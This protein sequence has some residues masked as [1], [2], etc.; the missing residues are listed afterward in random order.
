M[1]VRPPPTLD[2]TLVEG[3][4]S[5]WILSF[6]EFID[7]W[8]GAA[9]WEPRLI[10]L[11]TVVVLGIIRLTCKDAYGVTWYQFIHAIFSGYLSFMAVWLNFF[12]AETLTGTQEP[13]RSF[14]CEGPLTS[15][16]RIVPAI[17][18]GFG[19]FDI[20]DGIGHGFDFVR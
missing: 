1:T 7:R 3:T 9:E 12:A 11:V 16:H 17:T 8:G 18:M 10:G 15:L 20:L 4:V 19:F 6:V 5:E 13:L 14:L 2:S